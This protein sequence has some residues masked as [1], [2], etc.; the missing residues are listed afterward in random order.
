[1]DLIPKPRS[2]G[3]GVLPFRGEG[4]RD[5]GVVLHRD[6]AEWGARPQSH[7]CHSMGVQPI[8]LVMPTGDLTSKRD[9]LRTN[10]RDIFLGNTRYWTSARPLFH[11]PSMPQWRGLPSPLA[12]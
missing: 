2:L 9:P 4:S 8:A 10:L 1:M 5:R 3:P 6:V 12:Q 7:N 11:A